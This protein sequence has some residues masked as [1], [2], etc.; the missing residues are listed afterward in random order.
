MV[1]TGVI[2]QRR[3]ISRTTITGTPY[4]S[5]AN[6]NVRY[7]PDGAAGMPVV[8]STRSVI[9]RGLVKQPSP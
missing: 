3:M 8:D 6:V 1:A 4:D 2:G 9:G 5:P 7:F